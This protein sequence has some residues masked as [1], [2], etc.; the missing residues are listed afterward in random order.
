M[1]VYILQTYD[2]ANA[3]CDQGEVVGVFDTLEAAQAYAFAVYTDWWTGLDADDLKAVTELGT[4]RHV[5]FR[6]EAGTSHSTYWSG[7]RWA[8]PDDNSGESTI[9]SIL[10]AEVK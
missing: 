6:W 7:P 9:W 3:P 5:A 8:T 10:L 2:D 1:K 4:V